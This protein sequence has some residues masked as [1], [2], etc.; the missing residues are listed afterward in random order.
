MRAVRIHGAG[1]LRVEVLPDPQ[2][3]PGK[4]LGKGMKVLVEP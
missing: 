2:I 3:P 4:V 1:D